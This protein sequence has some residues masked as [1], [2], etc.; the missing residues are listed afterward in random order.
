MSLAQ[1]IAERGYAPDFMVRREIRRLVKERLRAERRGS[2]APR[3]ARY[4][5]L[6]EQL[7]TSP[8]ALNTREANAQHYE[9]ATEFFEIVLGRHLKYSACLWDD[10]TR[11]L[12]DAEARMLALYAERAALEDG[13]RVLDLGCGWGSFALWAAQRFPRSLITAVSNSSTQRAYIEAQIAAR[14]LANVRVV[15]ADANVLDFAPGS[16]DRVV[17]I[18]MFEHVRNYALLLERVARWLVPGGQLFVHIFCHRDLMYPFETDGDDNWMGRHFFTGG[19]M[20]A[21]DTL[22]HFQQHLRIDSTWFVSGRH[23][24]H[25]AAAWLARMDARPADVRRVLAATY[26]DDV[27]R[28][29]QRWRFFFMACEE[30]FGYGDGNEWH[31]C[32]Y[33]MVPKTTAT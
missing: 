6:I 7:R 21:A 8:V 27:D 25:T 1:E 15:T 18:E 3:A 4:A 19:L 23:Y 14:A 5:A 11:D 17:S 29:V 20:P 13:Q 24:A 31:V 10:D 22:T 28:W 2:G 30:L 16:F 26:G 9:V 12:D 32:H 33:R